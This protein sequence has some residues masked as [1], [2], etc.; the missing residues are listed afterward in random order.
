MQK[1]Y[2]V[3][4]I[5]A[6]SGLHISSYAAEKGMSVA[7]VE[8]GA[9]GGTCLNRGCIPSKMLIHSADVAEEIKRAGL[10]GIKA[11][12]TGIEWKKLVNRVNTFVDKDAW[13]IEKANRQTKNITIYKTQARFIGK[14]LLEVNKDTITADKIFICAG[15]RPSIPPIPGLQNVNYITSD[16]AL[17]LKNQPKKLIIIGGGY[18]AAELAH[19]F[20]GLGTEVTILQRG[21]LL[22]SNEDSEIAQRFTEVYQRKFN[23]IL[24]ANTLRV[25]KKEK[26]IAVDIDVQ[27]RRKTIAGDTLL[28]ATGRMPNTDV[29]NVKA[30]G[31]EVNERGFVKVNEYLETSVPGIWAIG[32]IAGIYM[33]K[34][35]A[36]LEADYAV[37]NAFGKKVPVDYAAM[38][39]AAFSSPQVAAVGKTEDELKAKKMPYLKGIYEFKNSGYGKAIEDN[40]GFV[41]V[42]VH[43]QTKEILGCHIIG[44]DASILIH[45]V[46]VAMKAK[47]GA[48]GILDAVHIHPAL[49]EVVQRAF[50]RLQ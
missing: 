2:D 36:N 12:I 38:P 10:F 19:F 45:E 5:G 23:V 46:I 48:N 47:L 17:R 29:L 25:H 11:K 26:N 49:S 41:K 15:A 34:H 22:M 35:S 14:K 16:E 9:F 44:T 7:V 3:I 28:V 43:P 40:D 31:I 42:L 6:G 50:E 4:V 24:N 1:R 32:D 13:E 37:N 20:G 21:N 30:S 8:Q 33:F 39:H 18:I 27:G